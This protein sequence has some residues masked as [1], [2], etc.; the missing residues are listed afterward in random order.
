MDPGAAL[1]HCGVGG[2]GGQ[3]DVYRIGSQAADEIGAAW[4]AALA[5]PIAPAGDR[6]SCQAW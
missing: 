1:R 4:V 5:N 2:V 6:R 3:L